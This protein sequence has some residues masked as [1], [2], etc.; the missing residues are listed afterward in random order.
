MSTSPY[1]RQ[2]HWKHTVF[3]LEEPLIVESN[4]KLCGSLSVQANSNNHRDLDIRIQTRFR[5]KRMKNDM[6]KLF[7]LR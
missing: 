4:E 7:R 6:D 5:G 3:Y 2:T 1:Y